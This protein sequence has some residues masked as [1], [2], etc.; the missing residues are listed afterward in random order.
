MRGLGA[1]SGS[2]YVD[3]ASGYSVEATGPG[4]A[5]IFDSAGDTLYKSGGAQS[6]L[7]QNYGPF[8][9]DADGNIY[10]GAVE[11]W[12]TQD[13]LTGVAPPT[14]ASAAPTIS[15]AAA[16]PAPTTTSTNDW[17]NQSTTLFGAIVKN[18]DLAVAGAVA[19][20]LLLMSSGKRR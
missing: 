7:L 1:Y 19:A 14:T 18:S 6:T 3:P 9:V 10:V 15:T 4:A 8:Y 12:D 5:T 13:G 11:I 20:F 2:Y 17:V 16:P